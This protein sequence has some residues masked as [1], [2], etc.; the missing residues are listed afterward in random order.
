MFVDYSTDSVASKDRF[1]SWKDAVC[2][3]LITAHAKP[4]E[5][6]KFQGSFKYCT[7]GGL[8]LSTQTSASH[9]WDR[10]ADCL[11]QYPEDDYWLGFMQKGNA[12]LEQN[13]RS[14]C[15]EDGQF[16]LYDAARTFKYKINADA[17]HIIRLPRAVMTRLTPHID[18]LIGGVLDA[19]RPGIS[20]LKSMVLEVTSGVFKGPSPQLP[21]TFAQT[22][23]D[24]L[25]MSINL[26]HPADCPPRQ[27]E[28]YSR[29]ASYIKRNLHDAAL[30]LTTIANAHNISTRTVTRLFVT[31]DKTPMNFVWQERLISCRKVLQ[32]TR[33]VNITQVALDHGFTDMSHFSQAFRKAF[34]YSPSS[35]IHLHS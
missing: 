25:V 11:R 23:F 9:N 14:T 30:N 8:D 28:L 4:T 12:L 26:Q 22:L 27:D 1:E 32:E 34:G 15:I 7:F 31:H 33:G 18:E 3:H 13:G 17:L 29:V 20:T 6:Q 19:Q 10:S 21:D 16:V 2:T 35:V 24:L 5:P